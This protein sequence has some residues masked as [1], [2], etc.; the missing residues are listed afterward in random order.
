MSPPNK[1]KKED[2]RFPAHEVHRITEYLAGLS[3][4]STICFGMGL[5]SLG[6][7]N[8][9]ISDIYIITERT[10]Q[11]T[12]CLGVFIIFSTF[13]RIFDKIIQKKWGQLDL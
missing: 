4:N 3:K 7:T 10:S 6:I 1:N 8:H 11:I 9:I 2:K 12:I 5:L 13:G